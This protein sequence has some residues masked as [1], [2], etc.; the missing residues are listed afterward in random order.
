MSDN[1]NKPK[2][3]KTPITKNKLGKRFIT[4]GILLFPLLGSLFIV[5]VNSNKLINEVLSIPL[6]IIAVFSFLLLITGIIFVIK[7]RK[8]T[9]RKLK[10]GFRILI[11]FLAT[12]YIGG[13][14]TVV[15]VLYVPSIGFK[16]WLITTAMTTMN[17]QYFA[18]WFYDDYTIEIVQENN[19]VIESGED[20]NPDLIVITEPD[21]NRT[22]FENKYEEE[23]LTKDKDNN[24][25]KI[26]D[27]VRPSFKGKLAVIY[28]ASK[29]KVA[30]S[31]GVGTTLSNSY[32]QY[33][34]TISKNNKAIIAMNGGGFYDPD[35]N[36][37]GGVPHG[38]VIANGKL[39][40]NNSKPLS[41]GGVIGFNS[42]NK[43]VLARISAQQALNSGI[44][45]CVEFGPFLIVNGEASFVKG[46]GGWGQ[47]PR[48]AIAQRKDGIVLFLVIDGRQ[49]G[50]IGADMNDLVDVLLDYGAYNASN[51]DGGTSSVMTL[52]NKIIT[53]PRN[54]NFQAKDRPIPNAWILVE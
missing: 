38:I 36:S 50:S 9:G 12:I 49:A 47:A 20:S 8:P 42:E 18:T 52:N 4:I 24:L 16:D 28:D 17:H 30:N 45:D 6:L 41:V 2:K 7:D 23:I 44:R 53:N 22:T 54:G 37:T 14:V 34:E 26:I 31:Q 43:L 13:A 29:V 51:L 35:W 40:A 39:I 27:I 3:E 32:G 10:L 19:Q 21:F 33:I 46:N 1:E 25:Y 5:S 48:S 11:G 15:T